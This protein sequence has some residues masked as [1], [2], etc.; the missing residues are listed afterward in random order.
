MNEGSL[1]P[2]VILSYDP[3]AGEARVKLP[4]GKVERVF[5]SEKAVREM[6]GIP[7]TPTPEMAAELSKI[8]R[9]EAIAYA[10]VGVAVPPTKV[11]VVGAPTVA[12]SPKYAEQHPEAVTKVGKYYYTPA[13]SAKEA[14]IAKDVGKTIHEA[15]AEKLVTGEVSAEPPPRVHTYQEAMELRRAV[16]IEKYKEIMKLPKPDVKLHLIGQQTKVPLIVL[17]GNPSQAMVALRIAGVTLATQMDYWVSRGKKLSEIT[18]TSTIGMVMYPALKEYGKLIGEAQFNKAKELG[19]VEKGAVYA[20]MVGKDWTYYTAKQ[21]AEIKAQEAEVK[22][23]EKSIKTLAPYKTDTDKYSL[24]N[25]LASGDSKVI[26]AINVLFNPKT[27][28]E[29]KRF[30]AEVKAAEKAIEKYKI[31]AL[32]PAALYPE[33][34]LIAA[35]KDKVP[36]KILNALF[37]PDA[38][39]RAKTAVESLGEKRQA[40]L[41]WF[42]KI[43]SFFSL[44]P[45]GIE[46]AKVT[47]LTT[48]PMPEATGAKELS[49][50]EMLSILVP[51]IAKRPVETKSIS[52]KEL[53]KLVLE[54]EKAE[55][56]LGTAGMSMAIAYKAPEVRAG[57]ERFAEPMPVVIEQAVK[58]GG[59]LFLG[60]ASAPIYSA[61]VT[62]HLAKVAW[63]PNKIKGLKDLGGGIATFFISIPAMVV[64]EPA[65]ATGELV[66]LFVVGP[67]GAA[68]IVKSIGARGVPSYI[69]TRGMGIEYSVVKV[70]IKIAN[71]KAV[72]TAVNEG[73]ARAMKNKSG[74]A[75]VKVGDGKI[76]LKIRSTPVSE[77]IGPALY[78]ATPAL[79]KALKKG[80]I[81]GTLYTS[82][83][84][85]VRFAE[86]SAKGIPQVNPAILMI[87]TK[88]GRVKW[89]PTTNLY[90][91]AK[92]MEAVYGIT[93]LQP[94]KSLWNRLTFGKAGDFITVHNGTIIPI[95]RF[96]EPGAIAPRINLADLVAIR[97]KT[98]QASLV[99]LIKGRKGIEIIKESRDAITRRIVKEV[100]KEIKKGKNTTNAYNAIFRSEA[101]RLV[102]RNL[103]LFERLYRANPRVF[104]RA[105]RE[106]LEREFR[107][108][109]RERPPIRRITRTERGQLERGIVPGRVRELWRERG[110]RMGLTERTIVRL[111][112]ARIPPER[113]PPERIVAERIPRERVPRERVP[114]RRIPPERM[115]RKRVPPERIPRLPIRPL[116]K[117]P[118]KPFIPSLSILMGK[119]RV[120]IPSGSITWR[121]GLYWKYIPPPF[122]IDKPITL[123]QP[124]VG[125]TKTGATGK[126]SAYETIQI[127]GKPKVAVPERV[128]VDLGWTDIFVT[129]YGTKIAFES[130]GE[131]TD[132]GK[133]MPSPTRGLS[134]GG[135][136]SKIRGESTEGLSK[137][138]LSTTLKQLLDYEPKDT[139]LKEF[140]E[141]HSLPAKLRQTPPGII[142][143]EIRKAGL[144]K[145]RIKVILSY[146]PD[147]ERA[148]VIAYLDFKQ[149]YAPTRG[150][151]KAKLQ[152][153]KL[154]RTSSKHKKKSL[155]P[156]EPIL[157]EVR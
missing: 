122:D 8:R 36:D 157:G 66:G 63:G 37:A 74:T 91:G 152:P 21:W 130:G 141:R 7:E 17:K 34:D 106:H 120:E 25:A 32:Y 113:L 83:H 28:A 70:P 72:V 3:E 132:V 42:G 102:S 109:V 84:L 29:T 150:H 107:E 15:R 142:A 60:A 39:D 137:L 114:P 144:D 127:I 146:L 155:E 101:R 96:K 43:K 118:T 38:V 69:P 103:R 58:F 61:I 46:E 148:R 56:E 76:R 51:T 40:S 23:F 81:G 134:V 13:I 41:S 105:Y 124:P 4:T 10:D 67:D 6:Y 139:A 89:S 128:S 50:R 11:E 111:R 95:W 133:G 119:E 82:P 135:A 86:S 94:V 1:P 151:P 30:I 112:E 5:A 16:G 129:D 22:V 93:K 59:G 116:E 104:E 153:I 136:V 53:F 33:Y 115:P 88:A 27:V 24:V 2:T 47:Y 20:G 99:D 140:A 75:I 18:P 45:E 71:K 48:P 68:R 108:I 97:I 79:T 54:T 73:I 52:I 131:K 145:A 143:D 26:A 31:P 92:E 90:K 138:P 57:I 121:Q 9:E 78:H 44:T 49:A 14:E 156:I 64:A 117:I 87:H 147:R 98:M 100:E 62:G 149:E 125:A 19:F 65:L 35:V 77:V 110:E 55:I 154:R 80:Q 123:R 126:R 85:A 12:V